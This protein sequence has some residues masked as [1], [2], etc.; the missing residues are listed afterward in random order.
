MAGVGDIKPGVT[1]VVPTQAPRKVVGGRERREDP[2]RHQ[3]QAP[4]DDRDK[5]DNHIDEYA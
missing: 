4:P 2:A 3:R 5:D 1:P